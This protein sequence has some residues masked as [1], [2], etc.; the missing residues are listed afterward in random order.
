MFEQV[1]DNGNIT[2]KASNNEEK[3]A[4]EEYKFWN[5]IIFLCN[6]IKVNFTNDK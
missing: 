2:N 5:N 6:I 4:E 3:Q 1:E